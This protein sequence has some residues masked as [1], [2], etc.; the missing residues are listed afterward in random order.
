MGAVRSLVLVALLKSGLRFAVAKETA[1]GALK[2]GKPLVAIED[3]W[4]G[5]VGHFTTSVTTT[6]TSGYTT[7]TL[8]PHDSSASSGSSPNTFASSNLGGAWQAKSSDADP[9]GSMKSWGYKVSGSSGWYQEVWQW[10]VIDGLFVALCCGFFCAFSSCMCGGKPPRSGKKRR[11][12]VSEP[13]TDNGVQM[14]ELLPVEAAAALEASPLLAMPP[15]MLTR[16]NLT[17]F[18]PSYSTSSSQQSK[19]PLLAPQAYATPAVA[20]RYATQP[21]YVPYAA[22]RSTAQFGH[23]EPAEQ[24]YVVPVPEGGWRNKA[25]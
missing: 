15:L 7:Q 4:K 20:M 1:W 25:K 5:V 18:T 14:P 22:P 6:T 19:R 9:S 2:K 17:S 21:S 13:E 3:A 12:S 23:K 24:P 8:T 10:I 11:R 16:P